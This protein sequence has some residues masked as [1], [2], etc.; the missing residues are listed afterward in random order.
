MP[1]NIYPHSNNKKIPLESGI[2]MSFSVKFCT[3]NRDIVLL[4]QCITNKLL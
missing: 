2:N 3:Q 4:N 1:V